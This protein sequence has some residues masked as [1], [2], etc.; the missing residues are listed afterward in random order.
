MKHIL[1]TAL[2]LALCSMTLSLGAKDYKVTDFGARGDGITL[3]TRSIQAAIDCASANGGGTVIVNPGEFVTGSIYLKDNVDLH[4]EE[5]A[6]LLG[7]LN[8]W[9]YVRD[10]I[11][12]WTAMVFA[13]GQDNIALTG[14]GVLD[15]RGFEVANR[16]V[17]YVHLGLFKDDLEL[18]RPQESNRPEIIHFLKCNNVLVKD[19]TLKDPACWTQQYELCNKLT[20]EGIKVDA[21]AYWNN[22]GLDVVDCCDVIVRNCYIDASDDAYCFKSHHVD[23]VSENVLVENC[24]GRSSASGVKFGTLT[25]GVFRHFVFKD[26]TIFDTFRSAIN[27]ASVDG[28]R[29]E[30]VLVD[31]LKSLNTG[32]PIFIRFGTRNSNSNIPCVKDIVIRNVY[33]EVPRGKPDAGYIYE[34]PV[35]L[36]PRNVCPSSILGLP[37]HRIENVLIEDVEIVYP[38]KTD[39]A[40]AFRDCTPEV[41]EAMPELEKSY[42]EFSQWKEEPAWGFYV[43]HAD[44]LTFKNVR[45]T[46]ADRDYRPAFVF[47][48]VD[49]VVFKNVQI[50]EPTAPKGKKEIVKNKTRHFSKKK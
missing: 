30:D 48:D 19:V 24:I 47:D 21:K 39:T 3:N 17:Q 32:N 38:G 11:V 23:G 50:V 26:I 5:G 16:M 8:P 15:C 14:K 1:R 45:I 2:V 6:V 25:K 49:G 37:D 13:V 28:G 12:K 10:P 41:L 43:R 22:D 20:I 9:D 18:D 44:D 27:I 7:S 36:P 31:G 40:I 29:V 46:V 4:L 34:G 35:P 42:P 33:A